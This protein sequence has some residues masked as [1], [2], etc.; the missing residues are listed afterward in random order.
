ME[1]V[2]FD[3]TTDKERSIM[4]RPLRLEYAGALHHVTARGDRREDIYADN[5]DRSAFL[6]LFGEVAERFNWSAHSYC[7]MTNHY[8]L[9]IETPDANL[10]AGMR[11]LNGVYTQRF[12][13]RHRRVGHVFQGRY[14]AA[15]VQ[16]ETYLLELA[17]YVVLN[18]VRGH[19]VTRPQDWPWSSH[20]AMLG[21]EA[22]PS[23]LQT[24]WLLAQFG[25]ARTSALSRYERFVAEGI[26]ADNPWQALKHQSILGDETFVA[27]FRNAARSEVLDEVSKIQRRPIAGDLADFRA[28][29]PRHEAMARAYSSGAYTMKDIADYF[30]VHYMTVSRAVERFERGMLECET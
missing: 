29:Y 6:K 30:G 22:V 13:K 14:H 17:R 24:D 20:R 10:A 11:Q 19:M 18:P 1:F 15:L 25:A 21:V 3:C 7:L 4:V 28:A 8:H 16:K 27:R 26:N 12:N 2:Q 23:W 5:E 9:V